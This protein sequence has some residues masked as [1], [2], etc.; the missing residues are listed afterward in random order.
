MTSVQECALP[1]LAQAS[2]RGGDKGCKAKGFR[3]KIAVPPGECSKVGEAGGGGE[4]EETKPRDEA[5]RETEAMAGEESRASEPRKR[6]K[7]HAKKLD[8]LF[9]R[10]ATLTATNVTFLWAPKF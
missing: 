5:R 4:K 9:A 1:S 7:G 3:A 6:S 10:V 8:A 2:R